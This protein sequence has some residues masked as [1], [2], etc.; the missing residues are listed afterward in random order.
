MHIV[1]HNGHRKVSYVL[2]HHQLLRRSGVQPLTG[3]LGINAFES[4]MVLS[5]RKERVTKPYICCVTL[6]C[7]TTRL[8][9][10]L[11]G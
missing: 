9:F 2:A 5:V 8:T 4:R 6:G 1:D 10:F 11:C 7:S 3:V